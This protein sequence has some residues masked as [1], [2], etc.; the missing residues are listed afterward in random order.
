MYSVSRLINRSLDLLKG[1]LSFRIGQYFLNGAVTTLLYFTVKDFIQGGIEK[2]LDVA[3]C[4]VSPTYA[5]GGIEFYSKQIARNVALRN[6][7]PGD[8]GKKIFNLKGEYYPSLIRPYK[9]RSFASSKQLCAD[10]MHLHNA[11]L[12]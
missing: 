11:N 8:Q 5:L 4:Q 3:A 10:Q 2:D 7:L 6:V 12:I 9:N 1:P